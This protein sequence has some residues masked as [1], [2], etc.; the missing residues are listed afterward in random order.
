MS[1]SLVKFRI[2]DI[3][4]QVAEGVIVHWQGRKLASGPLNIELDQSSKSG[5]CGNFDYA[6]RGAQADFRVLLTF[7]ELASVLESIGVSNDLMQ[8]VRATIRSEGQIVRDHG[9]RLSGQCE[10]GEHALLNM[11]ET[12]AL[13]L[14]GT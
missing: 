10:L 11:H 9:L 6:R 8:P 5:N 2:A 1:E 12:R 13:I 3:H 4:A 14:P 7:P